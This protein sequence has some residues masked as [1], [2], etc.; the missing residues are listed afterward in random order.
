MGGGGPPK[1]AV[2][3]AQRGR[4]GFIKWTIAGPLYDNKWTIVLNN[5][6]QWILYHYEISLSL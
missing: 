6:L 4:E 1:S 3:N 2:G 5:L